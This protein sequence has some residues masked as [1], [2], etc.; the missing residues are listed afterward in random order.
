MLP[1][2][3]RGRGEN[4]SPRAGRVAAG[5]R[6]LEALRR[7]AGPAC[8]R[9]APGDVAALLGREALGARAAALEAAAASEERRGSGTHGRAFP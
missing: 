7:S 5:P 3:A 9:G 6:R 4:P 1:H 2:F 8:A